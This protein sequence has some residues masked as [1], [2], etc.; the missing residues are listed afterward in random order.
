MRL[1]YDFLSGLI[2]ENI[3]NLKKDHKIFKKWVWLFVNKKE[4]SKIHSQIDLSTGFEKCTVYVDNNIEHGEYLD[5]DA[6]F[7]SF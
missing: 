7:F 1:E 2:F 3:Q 4:Q 6:Y 5:Q